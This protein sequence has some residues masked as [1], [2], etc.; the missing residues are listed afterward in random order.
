M[1][2]A[3]SGWKR[4]SLSV[5]PVVSWNVRS[6]LA[7]RLDFDHIFLGRANLNLV[8]PNNNQLPTA[9]CLRPTKT[10]TTNVDYKFGFVGKCGGDYPGLRRACRESRDIMAKRFPIQLR[11]QNAEEEIQFGPDD[12]F[13]IE[14]LHN[15]VY[16]KHLETAD[17]AE[18]FSLAL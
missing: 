3:I 1:E 4:I 12:I 15:L 9:T 16:L 7:I 14:E 10:R 11:S 18:M 5:R 2:A 17:Q 6:D 13:S 8:S